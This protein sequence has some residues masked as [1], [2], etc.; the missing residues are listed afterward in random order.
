MTAA[1]PAASFRG[2][3]YQLTF[4]RL[5]DKSWP[6]QRDIGFET[7]V[8]ILRLSSCLSSE[9]RGNSVEKA[10]ERLNGLCRHISTVRAGLMVAKWLGCT[11]RLSS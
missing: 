8:V 10:G 2:S 7:I 4:L 11:C 1:S 6:E 9:D 5:P 3:A